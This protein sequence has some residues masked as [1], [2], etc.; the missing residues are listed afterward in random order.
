M[1]TSDQPDP[2]FIAFL[3]RLID[4]P[5]GTLGEIINRAAGLAATA[6]GRRVMLLA[7]AAA[8]MLLARWMFRQVWWR[9]QRA[10]GR[11]LLIRPPATVN[12][13]GAVLFW[14]NLT[15]LLSPAWKR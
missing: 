8:A 3:G 2:P 11:L 15:G 6:D 14:R 10:R 9:Q 4:D 5:L 12:L 7:A 13:A 1:P